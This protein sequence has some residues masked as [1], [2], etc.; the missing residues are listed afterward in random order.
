MSV[1][2]IPDFRQIPYLSNIKSYDEKDKII[3]SATDWLLNPDEYCIGSIGAL[4]L[5][6]FWVF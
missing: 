3:F 6:E 4:K 2:L 1:K 5:S